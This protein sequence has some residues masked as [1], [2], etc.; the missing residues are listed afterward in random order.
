MDT[1]GIA[2]WRQISKTLAQEIGDGVHAPGGRL[3]A[4]ADLAARFGVNRHTVL[5]AV[6]HLQ[7]EGYVR[8]ERGGGIYVERV[9]P[10]RM[11]PRSRLEE[12]LLELNRVPG[13]EILSMVEMPAPR[14]VA[15]ALA[16]AIGDSVTFVRVLGTADAMP[17]SYNLNY[18]ASNRLPGIA[19]AFRAR[20]GKPDADCSTA[21]VLA[22]L[23]VADFRRK[24]IK[25]RTRSPDADEARLLKMASADNVLEVNVVNVDQHDQPIVYGVTAF[26]GSRVEFVLDL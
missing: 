14:A 3:P 24:T 18:F 17:I 6:S 9:I 8:T 7:D 23:G 11:G 26:C 20:L 10:Y 15:L 2:L 16:I 25:I 5:K 21:R 22:S 19:D 12:N 4:S 1:D 13:R